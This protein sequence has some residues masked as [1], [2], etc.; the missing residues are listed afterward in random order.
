MRNSQD[1]DDEPLPGLRGRVVV[2]GASAGGVEALREVVA[3]LPADL[4]APV[5]VVL[6]VRPEA[7][8]LPAILERAGKLPVSH[9][10]DGQTLEPGRILVAPPDRHLIVDDGHARVVR[11]PKEN[12]HRP[13]ID[14]LFRSAAVSY[15]PGAV[16]VVLSG[17]LY[18]GAAGAAAVSERGGAVL[19]QDPEEAIHPDMPRSAIAADH[20]VDVLPLAQLPEAILRLVTPTPQ[21]VAMPDADALNEE[22]R[23]AALDLDAVDRDE[24]IGE[25]APFGCPECGGVLWE[26][27]D[28]KLLRFRCRVGHAYAAETLLAAQAETFDSA[29]FVA[30]RALEERASLAKRVRN[31]L[32]EQN[33]SSASRYDEVIEESERYANVIRAVLAGRG[34]PA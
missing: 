28:G 25:R 3:G 2:I 34:E 9:A 16:A 8:H 5:L 4:P 19:V 18:D 10:T 14:P 15:G 13:A 30:L 11:G 1:V 31:R 26:Q 21:E 33:R 12:L 32:R 24:G 27:D 23:Y 7:S 17:S 22:V 29:L 20:P 6:H